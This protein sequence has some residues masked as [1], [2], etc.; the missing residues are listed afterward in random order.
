M[1]ICVDVE[2]IHETCCNCYMEFCLSQPFYKKRKRDH[3]NFYCPAGHP[4]HYVDKT[5]DQKKIQELNDRLQAEINERK[6]FEKDSKIIRRR[7]EELKKQK[8]GLKGLITKTKNRIKNG[9]FPCCNRSFKNLHAHMKTNHPN[10][11]E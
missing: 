7:N 6:F 2:M 4:Q 10:Y 5:E 9:V 8:A 1:G 11:G 3:E